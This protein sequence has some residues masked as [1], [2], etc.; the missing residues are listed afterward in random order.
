MPRSRATRDHPVGARRG[1]PDPEAGVASGEDPL[2]DGMEDPPR[3]DRRPSRRPRRLDQRQGKPLAHDRQVTAPVEA[4]GDVPVIAS[5]LAWISAGS[6]SCPSG[7][8][9]RRESSAAHRP[10][11]R[12]APVIGTRRSRPSRRGPARWAQGRDALGTEPL[13]IGRPAVETVDPLRQPGLDG[14]LVAADRIPVEVEPVVAVVGALDEDG[15][16]PQG[17]TTTASTIRPGM[18]VRFG[19][20]RITASSTS[21]STT[22][23]TRWPRRPPPSDSPT[24]PRPG[25]CRLRRRAGRGRRSRPAGAAAPRDQP[26]VGRLDQADR[27][28]ALGR[29]VSK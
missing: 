24:G 12:P 6:R 10:R 8:A 9:R 16:A 21:S 22:T 29:S 3:M 11:R 23:I 14:G 2:G 28:L 19:S 25:C 5:T 27:G 1:T 20:A 26:P 13:E 17:S 18:I 15:W 7:T 4:R